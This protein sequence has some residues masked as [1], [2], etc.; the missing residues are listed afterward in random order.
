MGK[1]PRILIG[2]ALGLTAASAPAQVLQ[3]AGFNPAFAKAEA[4]LGGESRLAAMLAQ[5]GAPRAMP[6]RPASYSLPRVAPQ[7]THYTRVE[8]VAAV[9]RP[10]VFGTVALK[11]SQTSLDLR[12]RRVERARVGGKASRFAISLRNLA[13]QNR[14]ESINRYVNRRV[15]FSD[16]SREYRRADL[17]AT[18][19]ETLA[20]GRG[21]CEDYA[22]AKLQMLRKAGVADADLYLVILKDLVRRSDHAVAVVRSGGRMLV[23]DN[24]TDEVLE[25]ETIY[26][27]R[28]VITFA[29]NGAW[30]HGYKVTAA[31]VELAHSATAGAVP[32]PADDALDHRSRRASLRALSTGLSR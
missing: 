1:G 4:I 12:W 11:V 9:D 15:T 10:D 25:S 27:Y 3:S 7:R 13:E 19:N 18:A 5:Q 14:I 23:L 8:S 17:W 29:A 22:I 16:D 28:P 30:T 2:A 24:G 31:P 32:A 20:R 26:D 21:D 6:L